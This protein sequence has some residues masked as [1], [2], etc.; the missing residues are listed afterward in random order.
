MILGALLE[1]HTSFTFANRHLEQSIDARSRARLT[2]DELTALTRGAQ[3]LTPPS[4]ASA[5]RNDLTIAAQRRDGTG[6]ETVRIRLDNP[7]GS[8]VR[9]VLASPGG[10]VLDSRTVATGALDSGTSFIRYFGADGIEL[11]PAAVPPVALVGC[12]L[13]IRFTVAI[14]PS[15][16]RSPIIRTGDVTPRDRR[17]EELS[18]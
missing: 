12:T 9:E 10:A 15:V 5:A 14:A 7:T 17:A 3:A 8:I 4:G 6:N 1:T 16:G 13:R 11:D 2:I 18:C